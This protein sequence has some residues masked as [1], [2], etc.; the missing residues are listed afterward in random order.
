MS[1]QHL[2]SRPIGKLLGVSSHLQLQGEL[3][4]YV[5]VPEISL[6]RIHLLHRIPLDQFTNNF[7]LRVLGHDFFLAHWSAFPQSQVLPVGAEPVPGVITTWLHWLAL[8]RQCACAGVCPLRSQV[9]WSRLQVT[10]F[11]EMTYLWFSLYLALSQ[12]RGSFMAKIWRSLGGRRPHQVDFNRLVDLLFQVPRE[13]KNG[14]WC[15]V[16]YSKSKTWWLAKKIQG[17]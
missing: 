14:S 10:V 6:E 4:P 15:S 17:M 8:V 13:L 9:K 7:L 1:I 2:M 12:S 16:L 11:S 5:A 3:T